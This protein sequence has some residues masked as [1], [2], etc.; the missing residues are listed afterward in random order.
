MTKVNQSRLF[1]PG[2]SVLFLRTWR[3]TATDAMDCVSST[4]S[5]RTGIVAVDIAVCLKFRRL[6][7]VLIEYD[8]DAIHGWASVRQLL[9]YVTD[10]VSV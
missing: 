6:M 5:R 9:S 2:F 7:T 1:D 8:T 3:H 10:R 4:D